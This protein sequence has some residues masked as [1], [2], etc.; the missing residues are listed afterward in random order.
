METFV[1]KHHSNESIQQAISMQE[2]N[3]QKMQ[4]LI[5][6]GLKGRKL[7][8]V[9]RKMSELLDVIENSE[10]YIWELALQENT[11]VHPSAPPRMTMQCGQ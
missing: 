5:S 6:T 3:L 10:H 9:Q 11:P 4:S 1:K 2:Q 8:E 7:S